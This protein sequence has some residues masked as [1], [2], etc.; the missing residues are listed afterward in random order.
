MS[1]EE[2]DRLLVIDPA[3]RAEVRERWRS[4]MDLVV[5]GELQAAHA[6]SLARLRKRSLDLGERWRSFFNSRDWIPQPR[7]RL[8][9]ALGSALAVHDSLVLLEQV[10]Q[11]IQGGRDRAEMARI[12]EELR[13]AVS[14]PMLD[15]Q[16]RWATALEVLNRAERVQQ[17]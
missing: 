5:W 1:P 16:N 11:E 9:N 10:A 12:L 17:E 14:G 13:R 3:W 6:G 4:L 8:K 2:V 7:E 15:L